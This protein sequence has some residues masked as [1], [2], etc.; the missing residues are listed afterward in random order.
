MGLKKVNPTSEIF[1]GVGGLFSVASEL[2][3]SKFKKWNTMIITKK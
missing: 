3:V 2:F 1:R